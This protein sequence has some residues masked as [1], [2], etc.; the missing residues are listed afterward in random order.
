MGSPFCQRITFSTFAF[1]NLKGSFA[2]T[3]FT[4]SVLIDTRKIWWGISW[5]NIPHTN[6]TCFP[7]SIVKLVKVMRSS[8][9]ACCLNNSVTVFAA[10]DTYLVKSSKFVN[11][12]L[13]LPVPVTTNLGLCSLNSNFKSCRGGKNYEHEQKKSDGIWP[14]K[15]ASLDC[16]VHTLWIVHPVVSLFF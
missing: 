10:T 4:L 6:S 7:A 5:G 15:V 13:K 9:T 16:V 1:S 8:L 14:T 3:L 11:S 2:K 12:Y